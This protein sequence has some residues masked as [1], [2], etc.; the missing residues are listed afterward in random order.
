M[1]ETTALGLSLVGLLLAGSPRAMAAEVS[2][3]LF[4]D[5]LD[6]RGADYRVQGSVR[7]GRFSFRPPEG[8][9]EWVELAV[10]ASVDG[11]PL[12]PF[13]PVDGT[14]DMR[15][16]PSFTLVYT[17]AAARAEL[18]FRPTS[19]ELALRIFRPESRALRTVE[20]ACGSASDATQVFDPSVRH[21]SYHEFPVRVPRSIEPGIAS[22]PPWLFS[23]I[24]SFRIPGSTAT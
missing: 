2:Y 19:T 20:V 15:A 3:S 21:A 5:S 1:K 23:F 14:T 8:S 12:P 18:T 16:A 7:E 4:S 10:S 13:A 11:R 6:L 22:P 17:N 24:S 9:P